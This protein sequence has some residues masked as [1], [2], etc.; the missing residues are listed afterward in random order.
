MKQCP[1]CR[2]QYTDDTLKFCLQDGTPLESIG[3]PGETETVV[4]HRV[5]PT[6]PVMPV[7]PAIVAAPARKQ[8]T[9]LIVAITVMTTLLLFGLIAGAYY[10]STRGRREEA[11]RVNVNAAPYT[12]VNENVRPTPSITPSPTPSAANANVNTA[13]TPDVAQISRDVTRA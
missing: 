9:G 1:A 7:G 8:N 6:S 5:L 3:D 4:S 2:S 11:A 10:I 12:A 13:P